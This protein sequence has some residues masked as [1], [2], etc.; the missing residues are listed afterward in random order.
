MMFPQRIISLS[1]CPPKK[2]SEE[3]RFYSFA[4]QKYSAIK[5]TPLQTAFSAILPTGLFFTSNLTIFLRVTKA[6]NTNK[7]YLETVIV[8]LSFQWIRITHR[9]RFTTSTRWS[10]RLST[11]RTSRELT[12]K[13]QALTSAKVRRT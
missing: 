9:C 4:T 5:Y 6:T 13:K 3:V 12:S 10:L 7:P 8:W 2:Q 1:R 11:T